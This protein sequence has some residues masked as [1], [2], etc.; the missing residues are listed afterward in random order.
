MVKKIDVK[1]LD[2][3]LEKGII[4]NAEYDYLFS[5]IEKGKEIDFSQYEEESG[6]VAKNI[7]SFILT[8][9]AI[10]AVMFGTC[11]MNIAIV[12]GMKSDALTLP[13]IIA[14]PLFPVVLFGW[15]AHKTKNA[16]MKWAVIF[17]AVGALLVAAMSM[18]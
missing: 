14:W 1:K 6:S 2:I 11:I 9:I 8:I 17:L 10:G 18:G 13:L 15:I 16:G 3:L 12:E 7:L 5:K 4:T